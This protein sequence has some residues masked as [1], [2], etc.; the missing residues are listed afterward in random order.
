MA[1][2]CEQYMS[3]A[4]KEYY[5]YSMFFEENVLCLTSG[6]RGPNARAFYPYRFPLL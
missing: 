1:P 4:V 2:K 6:R 3:E 5:K